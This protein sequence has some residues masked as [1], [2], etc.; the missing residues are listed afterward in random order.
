MVARSHEQQSGVIQFDREQAHGAAAYLTI[1]WRT[2]FSSRNASAS[3]TA[4]SW[5][6]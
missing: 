6:S 3:S 4:R 5:R 2:T 1:I